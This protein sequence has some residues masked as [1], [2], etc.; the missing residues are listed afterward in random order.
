MSYNDGSSFAFTICSAI[1]N[2]T[3]YEG[4]FEYGSR[5][6]TD[7]VTSTNV[8]LMKYTPSLTPNADPRFDAF[9]GTN[10]KTVSPESNVVLP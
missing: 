5:T 9:S 4:L 1:S 3:L 6:K 10:V 2:P 8:P 7:F